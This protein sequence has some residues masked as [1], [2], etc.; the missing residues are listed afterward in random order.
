[1]RHPEVQLDQ[2][3]KEQEKRL[4]SGSYLDFLLSLQQ[5]ENNKHT[6]RVI[7][8]IREFKKVLEDAALEHHWPATVDFLFDEDPASR[9]DIAEA[10]DFLK[11]QG[12]KIETFSASFQ[13]I[14][15]RTSGSERQERTG[16]SFI[17]F[18][19]P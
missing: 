1:M 12:I 17:K 8:Y 2:T 7:G 14:K 5:G 18:S 10:I 11:N 3:L 19:L 16:H 15:D 6:E 13:I 4:D 9:S